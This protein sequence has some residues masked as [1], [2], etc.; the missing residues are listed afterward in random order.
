MTI[1]KKYKYALLSAVSLLLAF[2]LWS[3]LFYANQAVLHGNLSILN[4]GFITSLIPIFD[5]LGIYCAMK[6][7][8]LKESSVGTYLG[9]I[10]ILAFIFILYMAIMLL[11]WSQTTG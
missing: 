9:I 6:S 5:I 2:G 11:G 8:K 3:L 1:I 7:I 4:S 10:G